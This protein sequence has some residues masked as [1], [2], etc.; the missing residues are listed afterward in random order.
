VLHYRTVAGMGLV[1]SSYLTA[2]LVRVG[3]VE[4][5]HRKMVTVRFYLT[6]V[7]PIGAFQALAMGFGTVA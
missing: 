7:L 2:I 3:A 6:R 5:H 4:L 1:C